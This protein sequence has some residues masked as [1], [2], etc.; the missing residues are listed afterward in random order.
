MHMKFPNCFLSLVCGLL[1]L[2]SSYG[3]V[4]AWV[5]VE[6]TWEASGGETRRLSGQLE[7]DRLPVTRL[8]RGNF[9]IT[10]L[11]PLENGE[12]QIQNTGDMHEGAPVFVLRDYQGAHRF[13]WNV[14]ALPVGARDTGMRAVEVG[15]GFDAPPP[16]LD[17]DEPG[18]ADEGA[19]PEVLASFRLVPDGES[20]R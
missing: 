1:G 11:V 15:E 10:N 17:L 3:D 14:A 2:F 20:P 19:D 4:P 16:V 8:E 13:L 6:V 7:F 18:P 12:I 5:G 9:G